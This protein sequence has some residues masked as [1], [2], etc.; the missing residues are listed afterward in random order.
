MECLSLV[1]NYRSKTKNKENLSIEENIDIVKKL[2]HPKKYISFREKQKIIVSILKKI[3]SYSEDGLLL[4]NSCDKYVTFINELLSVYTD[5]RIDEYSYDILCSNELLNIVIGS[6]GT[7]Y[8]VCLGIMEMYLEDLE[9]K[10]ID[11]RKM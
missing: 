7:E 2:I 11:L 9:H 6:L 5:L 8:D 3:I 4:Y 1:T 10:R